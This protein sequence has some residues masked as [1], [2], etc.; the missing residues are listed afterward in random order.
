M[1]DKRKRLQLA[2]TVFAMF[3]G[4]GNLIFPAFLTFQAGENLA[5]A[6]IGFAVTAIGFPVLSL[7]AVGRS[8]SLDALASRVHPVFSRIFTIAIY[9]AIGPC[10]AIPRTASTSYERVQSAAGGG[11]AIFSLL[12]SA[13]FFA[14]AAAV[15]L[16]PEK[17]SKRLGR[18]LA[19]ILLILIAVL[20]AG[21]LKAEPAAAQ[22]SAAYYSAPFASGFREGYQTMDAI[23]GLVFGVVISMNISALGMEGKEAE[24]EGIA[25]SA[26]GGIIL[27]MVYAALASVGAKAMA[28]T[29]DPSTGADILSSAAAYISS[30]YGRYLIAAIFILACFNTS[31]GLLSSTGE[32]FSRLLPGIKRG[33]WI[34][35]FAALSGMIANIGLSTIIKLSSPVLELIYPGA[36]TL[37]VLAFLKDSPENRPCC[38]FS[39]AAAL[40]SSLLSM[41]GV[42]LP[43]SEMGFGWLIPAAA[44]AGAGILYGHK[45]TLF[46][47]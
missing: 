20:F 4:A 16:R 36:I 11:S 15:A 34:A 31:V 47:K 44:A 40:L 41:L 30:E 21:T 14:A 32:Y 5:P 22:A 10:L 39:V 12:Y 43:L 19:P 35:L 29:T 2:F 42:P 13:L 45:R 9:L 25:A 18:I 3:F 7:I 23:A 1:P 8:G 33:W 24:K 37:I 6:F 38:V 27:L 28:F 26:G 46:Q 17:L